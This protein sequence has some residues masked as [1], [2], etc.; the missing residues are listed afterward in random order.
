MWADVSLA[1]VALATRSLLVEGVPLSSL[2]I[3]GVAGHPLSPKEAMRILADAAARVQA[4]HAL[5]YVHGALGADD[6]TVSSDGTVTVADFPVTIA[7][8]GARDRRADIFG[9]G[10]M[11]WELL[12]LRRLPA[13]PRQIKPPSLLRRGVPELVDYVCLHALEARPAERFQEAGELAKA[14]ETQLD[15]PIAER[16]EVGRYI[17]RMFSHAPIER[18]VHV[19]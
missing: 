13:D 1:A 5:G 14:L 12:A 18:V 16:A 15:D 3:A 4:A 8:A 17:E 11:L 2:F 7:R 6:V 10:T 19:L 9:L